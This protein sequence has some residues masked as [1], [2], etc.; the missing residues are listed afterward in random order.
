MELE[1]VEPDFLGAVHRGIGV[2]QQRVRVLAVVGII[3]EAYAAGDLKI[4]PFDE[5]RLSNGRADFVQCGGDEV[6]VFGLVEKENDELVAA[7]PHDSVGRPDATHHA[8]GDDL[9]NF[10]GPAVAERVI[11]EFEIIEIDEHDRRPPIVAFCKEQRL[12]EAILKQRTIG[13]P[14]Q[15]IMVRHEVDALFGEFSLNGN[16]SDA[17]CD[18]HEMRFGGAGSRTS[19]EY[20]A[21]VPRTAPR[22]EMIGVDQQER[23]PCAAASSR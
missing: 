11:D 4:V 1:T 3:G 12:G 22:C 20:I 9:Q 14:G 18:A 10:I 8:I 15:R 19:F 7:Q 17:G 5:N 21:K 13:E 16:A 23:R 6:D 2:G